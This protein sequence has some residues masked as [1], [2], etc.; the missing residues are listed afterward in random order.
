MFIEKNRT[1]CSIM[2]HCQRFSCGQACRRRLRGTAFTKKDG[3][4][5]EGPEA[6]LKSEAVAVVTKK[7][8]HSD[9]YM[10][11]GEKRDGDNR[12]QENGYGIGKQT[13]DEAAFGD[14]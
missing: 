4:S 5:D 6:K 12:E 1:L 7:D 14:N 10:T 13:G 8:G 3:Y 11:F 9:S 2:G